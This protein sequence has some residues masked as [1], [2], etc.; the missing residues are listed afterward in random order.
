V[1]VAGRAEAERQIWEAFFVFVLSP[2]NNS[3]VQLDCP[4]P[5]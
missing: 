2:L 4:L 3:E 5:L 1:V